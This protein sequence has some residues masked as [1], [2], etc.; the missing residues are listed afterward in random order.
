MLNFLRLLIVFRLSIVLFDLSY[1]WRLLHVQ[2]I[3]VAATEFYL[4]SVNRKMK[5]EISDWR[6]W[7][8]FWIYVDIHGTRTC[9]ISLWSSSFSH[10]IF[11]YR[12]S[13]SFETASGLYLDSALSCGC[14]IT[15]ITCKI[16]AGKAEGNVMLIQTKPIEH[17]PSTVR[18]RRR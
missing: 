17:T 15:S 11:W 3:A 9:T 14:L 1:F 12:S 5:N 10:S 6:M 7:S 8:L 13:S 16:D 2:P 18:G 4:L